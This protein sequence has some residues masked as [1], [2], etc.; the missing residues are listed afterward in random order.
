MTCWEATVRRRDLWVSGGL[1]AE[2]K[3]MSH[4]LDLTASLHG[5]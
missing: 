2:E 3:V 5:K 4:V 1:T